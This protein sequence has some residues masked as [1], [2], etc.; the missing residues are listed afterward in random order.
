MSILVLIDRFGCNGAIKALLPFLARLAKTETTITLMC[1]VQ[2]SIEA[3]V[4]PSGIRQIGFNEWMT[5]ETLGQAIGARRFL[6]PGGVRLFFRFV[7]LHLV[8]RWANCPSW[9]LQVLSSHK[10]DYDVAISFCDAFCNRYIRAFR[11][12]KYIGWI[13]EDY[14]WALEDEQTRKVQRAYLGKL[15]ALCCVSQHSAMIM[16]RLLGG[17]ATHV[18][19]VHNYIE[20]QQL[21]SFSWNPKNESIRLLSVGRL[22][23]VKRFDWCIRVASYLKRRGIRFKWEIIGDGPVASE[24][25]QLSAQLGVN[26][27]VCFAGRKPNPYEAMRG[28]TLY[29]QPSES[30]GWGLALEE[31]LL[32]GCP[33]VCTD[34]PVFHEIGETLGVLERMRFVQTPEEMGNLILS[35][36]DSPIES[37]CLTMTTLAARLESIFTE[38]MQ[39]FVDFVKG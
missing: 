1:L 24:L 21:R 25:K 35:L 14:S 36:L 10:G 27:V 30:E 9:L 12:R 22:V 18:L 28:C 13:H 39:M 26:N 2:E 17:E 15:T 3:D 33:V 38:E 37:P 31:A 20:T 29:V 8:A 4:L 34:L 16:K 23:K 7:A 32:I 11:A 19:T 5:R 6:R